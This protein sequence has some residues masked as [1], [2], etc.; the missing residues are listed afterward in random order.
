MLLENSDLKR[1]D[2]FVKGISGQDRIAICHDL[3]ADGISSGV[4]TF[5]AIKLLR[6]KEPDLVITQRYK[7]VE[8]LDKTISLLEENKINKLIIVD[9]AADQ[10][11]D[12]IKAAEKVADEIL[13]IDHHKNYNYKGKKST[14][15]LKVQMVSKIEPSK[16]PT[17]KFTYD[18]FSRHVDLHSHSWVACAGL[19]GDN[20]LEQWRDFVSKEVKAHNCSINDIWNVTQTIS[21]IEVLAP[22]KLHELLYF[23]ASSTSPRDVFSSSFAKYRGALDEDLDKYFR[24]FKKKA[25]FFEKEELV[26]FEFVA[27]SNIKSALINRVTNELY[28]NKTVIVVQ[29]KGDG[30]V[31]FSC[32]RQDFKVKTNELLENAVKGFE[33][34]GAGGHVPASA[35]R[36]KKEDLKEFKK[37]ILKALAVK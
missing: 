27:K 16:Y 33:N 37:R 11:K 25:E 32:R 2:S 1:F 12:S 35:G 13:V 36:I 34:A 20:Q 30:F 15:I 6:K 24:E 29:H 18:L 5:L 8:L 31:S 7:T 26:W 28:P 4:I 10:K 23:I 3:D 9:F 19:M 21:A 17:A 22:E 14:F